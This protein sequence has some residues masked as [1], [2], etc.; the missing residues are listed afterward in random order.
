MDRPDHVRLFSRWPSV[1]Y[2]VSFNYLPPFRLRHAV[3]YEAAGISP[4]SSFDLGLGQTA[5]GIV[6]NVASWFIRVFLPFVI[7]YCLHSMQSDE[8][9]VV[10]YCSGA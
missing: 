8:S 2:V 4:T 9:V 1:L 7:S 6:G 5:I 10:S 3:F